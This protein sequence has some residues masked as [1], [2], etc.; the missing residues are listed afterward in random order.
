LG[1]LLETISFL[2]TTFF[3]EGSYFLLTVLALVWILMESKGDKRGKRMAIYTIV[4]YLG[5]ICNPLVAPYGLVFFGEDRYAYLRIFYLIPLVTVLAYGTTGFYA[6]YADTQ[7][8]KTGKVLFLAV[9]VLT[10]MMSGK[11]YGSSMYRTVSNIYKIDQDAY[12]ISNI[13]MENSDGERPVA[14]VPKTEDI[15]YG[16]RQYEGQIIL[17]GDSNTLTTWAELFQAV[18]ENELNFVVFSKEDAMNDRIRDTYFQ[19]IG[20]TENYMIYKKTAY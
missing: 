1:A 20:Q 19:E 16:I 9:L 8:K 13:L 10:V 15:W 5:I 3:K 18:N 4:C 12:E 7:A 2:N 17:E 6:H 11:I 14:W